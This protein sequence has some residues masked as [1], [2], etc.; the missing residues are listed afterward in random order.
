MEDERDTLRKQLADLQATYEALKATHERTCRES[1]RNPFGA[2]RKR[3]YTTQLEQIMQ[4]RESGSSIRAI[5]K[6]LNIPFA[7]VARY[8]KENESK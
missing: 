2:G 4:L 5:A 8:I 3:S 7:T 6:E 1:Q